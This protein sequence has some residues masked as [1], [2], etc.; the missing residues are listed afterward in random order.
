MLFCCL[1]AACAIRPLINRNG[2]RE[3]IFIL[4]VVVSLFFFDS[5]DPF[6]GIPL[7]MYIM[8][9]SILLG[10]FCRRHYIKTD[11]KLFIVCILIVV[12]M[13]FQ[14]IMLLFGIN[15]QKAL[16]LKQSTTDTL[17]ITSELLYPTVN[18][19]VIK[20]FLFY[21]AY[22]M[23]LFFN[24][25]Y[26]RNKNKLAKLLKCCVKIFKLLF[27]FL[28]VE[29]VV[30]NFTGLLKDR[31][32]ITLIF[33]TSLNQTIKWTSYSGLY[34]SVAWFSEASNVRIVIIY[35]LIR[36]T[37]KNYKFKSI[38]WDLVSF[39]AVFASG[40]ST[41]LMI[42]AIYVVYSVFYLIVVNRYMYLKIIGTAFLIACVC[43]VSKY[44]EVMF[45]K[46]NIFLSGAITWGSA[47][48]RS[49]SIVYALNIIKYHPLFGLGIGTVYS[50]SGLFQALANIGIVGTS[51]LVYAHIILLK[52]SVSFIVIVKIIFVVGILFAAFMI[53]EITSPFMCI[54]MMTM[55]AE[56]KSRAI[57]KH[58]V[59]ALVPMQ[60][61]YD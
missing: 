57:E 11:K 47:S 42:S 60:K 6:I 53:Q 17:D 56:T 54:L 23:F 14:M 21:I 36:I 4:T 40:G 18:F 25:D 44:G 19:T 28:I 59:K 26:L 7:Y 12:A 58:T 32:I 15:V 8:V 52:P 61:S 39:F 34:T 51:L 24:A 5:K 41:A 30:T 31:N 3:F 50:H 27:V 48:A 37:E 10:L 43:V 46:V 22:L 38:I 1:C 55:F 33:N 9:L 49:Q 29:C 20:H 16:L 35:Y 13:M 2:Y 45:A